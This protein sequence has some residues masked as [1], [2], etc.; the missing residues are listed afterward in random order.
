MLQA[1]WRELMSFSVHLLSAETYFSPTGFTLCFQLRL[2]LSFS[3]DSFVSE[4][5]QCL[6]VKLTPFFPL[7]S[8]DSSLSLL[9]S[10]CLQLELIFFASVPSSFQEC[11]TFFLPIPFPSSWITCVAHL[12]SHCL[13]ICKGNILWRIWLVNAVSWND[14][15]NKKCFAEMPFKCLS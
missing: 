3:P 7:Y 15:W 12:Q 9:A 1:E 14:L 6:Q 10:D 2:L 5:T 4:L 8:A 11:R 13:L